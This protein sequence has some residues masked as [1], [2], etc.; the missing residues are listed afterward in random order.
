MFD[1]NYKAYLLEANIGPAL[2]AFTEEYS[3]Q[4]KNFMKSMMDI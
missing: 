4:T 2:L 1:E 3:N